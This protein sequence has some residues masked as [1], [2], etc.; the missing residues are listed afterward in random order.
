MADYRLSLPK[1][2]KG[3]FRWILSHPLFASWR[4]ATKSALLWLT[5]HAGCGKTILS[6]FLMNQLEQTR[7]D[8]KRYSI[9]IYFCDDNINKQKDGRAVLLGLIFQI[10]S[11]HRSLVRHAKKA[12]EL[13]GS[14]LV[15][16]FAALWN[17]FQSIVT[18]PRAGSVYIIIDALDEC[19]PTT[20]RELLSS[21]R[22]MI[23]SPDG[24]YGNER[25]V[26]FILSSRPYFPGFE[27]SLGS[28]PDQRLSI[29]EG[30]DAYI[31][32]LEM[33]IH[34]RM[35]EISQDHKL[36]PET[37]QYLQE[38]LLAKADRTFLWVH[39]VL[40]S[41]DNLIPI[42]T[43]DFQKKVDEIP[44]DL[45]ATYRGL[46]DKIEGK[47]RDAASK[48]LKLVL[49]SSRPLSLD[50]IGVALTLSYEHQ[51]ENELKRDLPPSI[52]RTLQGTL[53]PLIRISDLKVSLIHQSAKEF[54]MEPNSADEGP[55]RWF[56]TDQEDISLSLA[57]VCIQYLSL[58]DFSTDRFAAAESFDDLSGV[59]DDSDK[60]SS[61][62]VSQPLGMDI[63]IEALFV[64]SEVV[65]DEHCH[66]ITNTHCFYDY[67]SL[68]WAHHFARCQA[69]APEPLRRDAAR[70]L[71]ADHSW[72]ASNWLKYF[73]IQSK[74]ERTAVPSN[75]NEVELA[76]YFGFDRI[77]AD[78]L[79][80]RVAI[81][82]A[83][84]N[85]AL[86]WAAT[87][88]HADTV[89]LLLSAAAEPNSHTTQDR[90][91]PLIGAAVMGSA[92]CVKIL[93]RDQRTDI[94][95]TDYTG[96]SPLLMAS[97]YG[98]VD[99][100]KLL[101]HGGNCDT[102]KTD[103]TGTTP[104][105]WAAGGGYTRILMEL[106]KQPGIEVNQ[107]DNSG[108]TAISW[109]AGE[110]LKECLDALVGNKQ[111]DINLSDAKGLSPLMWAARNGQVEAIRV[112]VR[113]LKLKHDSVDIDQ[114]SAISWACGQGQAD[115]VK[116]LVRSGC[117]GIN[118][119]DADGWSPLLWAIN[120]DSPDTVRAIL[121]TGQ[122]DIE[123]RDAGGKTALHWAVNF[124]HLRAIRALLEKGADPE[125]KTYEGQTVM[126]LA[127]ELGHLK[128]INELSVA[129][130]R[131][132]AG[133]SI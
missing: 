4:D 119:K 82:Q 99:V 86:Y 18:D 76:A 13:Q 20:R 46:L 89:L 131:R 23:Q 16:S 77:I 122:V 47:D 62:D 30:G 123:D 93:L 126:A 36:S 43:K 102:G 92:D 124:S 32:D 19:E 116:W 7:V 109:A 3:T 98:H 66:N 108:R 75:L 94:N 79:Q 27:R 132:F 14:N 11:T 51:D 125:A 70:L 39:M 72:V 91:T 61:N 130:N 104:L 12:F 1:P 103:R 54:L 9:C 129:L 6:S 127:R 67:A 26:K 117:T 74:D 88:N 84:R 81:S 5:G 41:F 40:S 55:A 53:G 112:L 60:S 95:L 128:V 17:V 133:S 10:L 35:S 21:I 115:A 52:T 85:T 63:G 83:A 38:Y 57:E 68:N 33:Y 64:E 48:L 78:F 69:I 111:V 22:D 2:A 114:R 24:A 59:V 37:K 25:S 90:H 106:L 44:A 8:S 45:Q 65:E 28:F 113:R 118:Q 50:E 73:W 87:N 15:N 107:Q 31:A 101:L 29:D 80:E 71:K 96:R 105:I 49:G 100:A 42:S 120:R 121:S 97:K 110:G 56:S 34:Q 58:Q